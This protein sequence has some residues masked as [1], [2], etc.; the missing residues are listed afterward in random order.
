[1]RIGHVNLD[2]PVVLAPMAGVTDSTFRRLVKKFG[3][4]LVCAEM[5]SAKALTFNNQKTMEM[6]DYTSV[7]KPI[8]IQIF[9]SEPEVMAQ[10]AV[11]VEQAGADI[12]DINM[13]C[14]VSKVV[15]NQEGSALMKNPDLAVDIVREVVK[16]VKNPVTVK[17][18]KG[19]SS[20]QV[21]AVELAKRVEE[22]GAK[23][24]TVHGRTREQFYSGQADWEIIRQVKEGVSIP[25]IGSGDIFSPEDAA[26]M[27]EQ[28]GCDGLMIGRGSLGNPWLFRRTVHYLATGELLPQ[29]SA[30]E[31]I[32]VALEHLA[33]LVEDKGE[34]LGVREMRKHAA[35]YTKGLAQSA[36]LRQTINQ[37]TTREQLVQILT[38]YAKIL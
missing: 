4:G 33:M 38:N 27:K 17:M 20:N 21:N 24:I 2:N 34:Y 22:A 35:W 8:S 36:Q 12:I 26:R 6:L 5:V 13:G 11:A 30:Q 19:W 9:G 10:G 15:K 37:A 31:R 25:V 18:R 29:P 14:P 3:C 1:M 16:A 32:K 28:T 7:E 23:A